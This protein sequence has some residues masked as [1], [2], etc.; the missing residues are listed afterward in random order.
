MFII[1]LDKIVWVRY[2]GNRRDTLI[3]FNAD[4]KFVSLIELS[5]HC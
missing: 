3:T 2:V 4:F 1:L 5:F